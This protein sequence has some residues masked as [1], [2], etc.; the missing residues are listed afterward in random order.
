MV[1]NISGLQAEVRG[2]VGRERRAGQAE[3]WPAAQM[4][5]AQADP[6]PNAQMALSH[7]QAAHRRQADLV[8]NYRALCSRGAVG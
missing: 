4:A 6:L 8:Y 3:V 5:E 7:R 2:L 1:D